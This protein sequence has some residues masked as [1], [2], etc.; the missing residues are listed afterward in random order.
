[1]STKRA[2]LEG[3]APVLIPMTAPYWYVPSSSLNTPKSAS[4]AILLS[5]LRT[6]GPGMSLV[7][8]DKRLPFDEPGSS[9]FRR[10]CKSSS[11]CGNFAQA[12]PRLPITQRAAAPGIESASEYLAGW[13]RTHVG[14]N[15]N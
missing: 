1:M 13:E 7:L 8:H 6:D 3:S 12:P 9:A 5:T 11:S 14:A 15:R 10:T 4:D 2:M